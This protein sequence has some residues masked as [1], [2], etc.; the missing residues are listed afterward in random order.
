MLPLLDAKKII[1]VQIFAVEFDINI[2]FL[3]GFPFNVYNFVTPYF[4]K[5]ELLPR[6]VE[7]WNWLKDLLI[8]AG[9]R[10]I[11]IESNYTVE[12]SS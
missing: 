6:L 7:T 8:P 9:G 1:V 12:D 11:N 5:I 3:L 4:I 2:V 10:G